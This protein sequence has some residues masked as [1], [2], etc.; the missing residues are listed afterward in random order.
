MHKTTTWRLIS[1]PALKPCPS[2][3]PQLLFFKVISMWRWVFSKFVIILSGGKLFMKQLVRIF[4]LE[5]FRHHEYFMFPRPLPADTLKRDPLIALCSYYFPKGASPCS[6][7]CYFAQVPAYM[8]TA[9]NPGLNSCGGCRLCG[10]WRQR[11]PAGESLRQQPRF[12]LF[13]SGWWRLI[14]WAPLSDLLLLQKKSWRRCPSCTE[15]S[16]HSRQE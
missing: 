14:S 13:C 16:P 9:S 1:Y 8:F 11:V 3:K 6:A 4:W 12:S 2:A 5:S 10:N 15:R 7:P